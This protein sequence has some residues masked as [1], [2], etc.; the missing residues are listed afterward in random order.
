[1]FLDLLT[2]L[3]FAFASYVLMNETVLAGRL[4]PLFH[5]ELIPLVAMTILWE[6]VHR[7]RGPFS[8]TSTTVV[9]SL[10]PLGAYI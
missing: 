6:L 3:E 9:M 5:L 2:N 1:M 7:S 4:L 8:G 10:R